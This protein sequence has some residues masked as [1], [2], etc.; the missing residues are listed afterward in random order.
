[1]DFESALEKLQHFLFRSHKK[2]QCQKKVPSI[3]NHLRS[4]N[5]KADACLLVEKNPCHSQQPKS[6]VRSHISGIRD[7]T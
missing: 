7:S 4:K 5:N 1:M 3:N 6:D 2:K